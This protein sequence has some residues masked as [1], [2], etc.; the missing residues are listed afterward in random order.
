MLFDRPDRY[1][2]VT[3]VLHWGMAILFAA[4]FLS[5][6]ARW[7]LPRGDEIRNFFWSY[8]YDLGVTLFLLILLRGVWGL[9]N[10]SR[11]PHHWTS[12]VLGKAATLGHGALYTLMIV[13]PATRLLAA[14]GNDR[15]FSYLGLELFSAREAKV[16]WMQAPAQWH[17]EMGWLLS[18]LIVGHI[19]FAIGWH[20]FI[21]RD[22]TLSRMAGRRTMPTA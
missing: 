1:G 9:I 11:R 4:Q 17:G 6:A 12:G 5:A 22:A 3:R 10:L 7:A 15:S 8:H 16:A 18:L 14:A 19:G 21:R 2:T 13:V 20:H